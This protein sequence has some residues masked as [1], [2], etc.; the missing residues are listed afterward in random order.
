MSISIAPPLMTADELL[1][2]PRGK[3]RYE[4]V[5]GELREMPPSG[6]EHGVT[7][8]DVSTPLDNFVREHNLGV[9]TGA[10]TGFRLQS[11]PDTVRGA[12]VAFVSTARLPQG[13]MRGYFPG[14][15]DLAV[16]VVSPG[17]TVQEVDE[18]VTE[19]LEGGA[20]LVWIVRPSRRT[21]EV[22][23]AD[24]TGSLLNVNDELNGEDVVPG[25]VLPVA[26][27]FR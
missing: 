27:I 18:K 14:A 9:V 24:G 13:R 5:K 15:P 2:L 3:S 26:R 10:E 4:L 25:F 8:V 6:F 23:R 17:D 21:V 12:D 20:R 22:H 11:N 19:W 16:E 1:H 7:V